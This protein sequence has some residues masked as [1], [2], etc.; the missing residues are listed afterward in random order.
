MIS[1][2]AHS[3][4]GISLGK[5]IQK[6]GIEA[7]LFG[8][9]EYKPL[10]S[11]FHENQALIFIG[12]LGICI[13]KIAPLLEDKKQDPAIINI[14]PQGRYVQ[15]VA[16]GHTGGANQLANEIAR[17]LG[18][19]PII[20][21]SSDNSGLWALDMLANQHGWKM[22]NHPQLTTLMAA[23]VNDK[24]TALLLEIRDQGTREMENS[25]PDH[26]TV[27]YKAEEIDTQK[28]SLIIAVTP[29]L[30]DLGP[31]A[32][33]YRPPVIVLGMGAQKQ[34]DP[35]LAEEKTENILIQQGIS[36]L[37]IAMIGTVDMKKKEEAFLQM[38]RKYGE[39][40]QICNTETLS[41]YQVPNPSNKV[42]E[43]TGLEGVAEATAM[44]LAQNN[45]LIEKTAVQIDDKQLT[46][47]AAMLSSCERKGYIY[48]VGAGPGNPE[49]ITIK[50][51]K[52]LQTADLILY[53]GSLVP[54]YLLM[55]TKEGC[56]TR[57]SA[58][59]VL[60]EQ[61]VL[62]KSF[63]DKGLQVVRLHTGDPC[64]YGAIQ[65]QMNKMDTLGMEYEIVPGVSSFQAAASELKSQFTIPEEVQTIILTRGE[66][67]TPMP[68]KEQLNLLARSQSTM[69]IY[70]SASIVEKTE[71]Q[72]LEHYPPGTPA[73]ICYK[74]TWKEQKIYRCHLDQ[75][76]HTI[77]KHNINM[78][79]LIVVGKAIDNRQGESKLYHKN[80]QHKFRS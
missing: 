37:S 77:K 64:L 34:V 30:H 46:L 16:S 67:R 10:R 72:L 22:E 74:L 49:L 27:Y 32:I 80:F 19:L 28:Y 1:I 6:L 35:K 23:F 78:T 51:K 44:H 13:R 17:L 20:T 4:K 63:Y 25:L 73:A 76:A 62:M 55:Y 50:G 53:A 15:A 52:L 68:D 43:V 56:V 26:V 60:E 47:A 31:K 70:L 39:E 66:G 79:A 12:A 54:K 24:P 2:I 40:L 59:M 9:E 29:F 38:A 3:Q 48:I 7:Q 42:K 18:A 14:D 8:P 69:C 21:T 11:M 45:L 61:I 5:K 71:Q 65:E 57:N 75:L 33:Y 41:H 58:F 36:P